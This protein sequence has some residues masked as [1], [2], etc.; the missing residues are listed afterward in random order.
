MYIS[1]SGWKKYKDC[2]FAYWHDY[3][4]HTPLEKPD[5]RLGSIY[6]SVVGLLFEEFYNL[7]L[8]KQ[9][10]PKD[11]VLGRVEEAVKRVVRQETSARKGRPG[12]VLR[13]KGAG[14]GR[15][16]KGMYLDEAD[17]AADV[18]EAVIRG[19]KIIKHYRLL[20]PRAEAEV[21]LDSPINGH[22][23][24]GRADFILKRTEPHHD[25]CILD[26]K[27][28][29]YRG[30]Y[31]SPKQL[32][33]YTMLYRLRFNETPDKLGFV[34]WRF[35]PPESMDWVEFSSADLDQLLEGVLA[36]VREIG[37]LESNLPPP[38][39]KQAMDRSGLARQE[40]RPRANDNNCRF[41]PHATT[42]Q[43]SAGLWVV[44]KMEQGKHG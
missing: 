11:V 20:G 6:G 10:Q 3:I 2:P 34:Y 12:G 32:H 39:E 41:C 43:C 17:L 13:W 37:R 31:V 15:N 9:P 14:E 42:T 40:F 26:G 38:N 7:R 19:F 8:W 24:G 23:L 36:D 33:W 18:R 30:T 29:K 25:L 16:S 5:D 27:G 28:S 35:E 21:K 4:N 22:I 44:Q 1:Y